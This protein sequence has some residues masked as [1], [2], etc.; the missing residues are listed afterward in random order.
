MINEV[1]TRM[2]QKWFLSRV[3]QMME[4]TFLTSHVN[5]SIG[6]T[7]IHMN[8]KEKVNKLQM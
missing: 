2:L 8:E 1:T 7:S 6:M 4:E 5:K 3:I